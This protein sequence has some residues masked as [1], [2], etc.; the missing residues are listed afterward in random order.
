MVSCI[1]GNGDAAAHCLQKHLEH[2]ARETPAKAAHPR[3]LCHNTLNETLRAFNLD[4]RRQVL[5][6]N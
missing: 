1:G 3:S 6:V 4:L 5:S 2:T